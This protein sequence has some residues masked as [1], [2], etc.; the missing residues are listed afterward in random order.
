MNDL[1]IGYKNFTLIQIKLK[2]EEYFK[3]LENLAKIEEIQELIEDEIQQQYSPFLI[4]L[5][6]VSMDNIGNDDYDFSKEIKD[7]INS[8]ISKNMENINNI[9]SQI[10]GKEYDISLLNWTRQD[11]EGTEFFEYIKEKMFMKFIN[12][13]ID[14][15]KKD[16]N[17]FLKEIIRK[18]FNNLINNL[19]CSFGNE[20][21]ERILKYNENFKIS[22]LYLVFNNRDLKFKFDIFNNLDLMIK[23]K[24]K[25]L[26]NLI[27]INV[28]QFIEESQRYLVNNYNNF[29]KEDSLIKSALNESIREAID[30]NLKDV[31]S[32]LENDFTSLLNEKIKNEISFF[33]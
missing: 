14:E 3:K 23:E 33:I 17:K 11:F 6:S 24:N 7:N 32:I 5:N 25:K 31:S 10:K 2:H 26:L 4:S 19:I 20:Y 1:A 22:T 27:N 28:D 12:N 15:E 30:I 8:E 21:F 13:K 29:F 9:V 18:N 16:L